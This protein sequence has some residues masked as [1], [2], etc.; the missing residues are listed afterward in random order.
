MRV[1]DREAHG[2]GQTVTNVDVVSESCPN[3][4]TSTESQ[5]HMQLNADQ[6]AELSEMLVNVMQQVIRGR[7][8]GF[9]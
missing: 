1:R 5:T 7:F 9:G 8:G 3:A 4:H 2:Q 6:V